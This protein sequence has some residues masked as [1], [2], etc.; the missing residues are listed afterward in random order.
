MRAL[1]VLVMFAVAMP[2]SADQPRPVAQKKQKTKAKPRVVKPS[3]AK[4]PPPP[5]VEPTAPNELSPEDSAI[6]MR[7]FN[8]MI[9]LVVAAKGD[10]GQIASSLN[11]LLDQ[12]RELLRKMAAANAAGKQLPKAMTDKMTKRAMELMPLVTKCG[13]DPDVQDVLARL[14][15]ENKKPEPP[16]IN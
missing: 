16:Q 6:V 11:L 7:F 1:L 4:L 15:N 14:Q 12:N 2:A 13:D 8:H 9:D 5:I 10:C 3:P